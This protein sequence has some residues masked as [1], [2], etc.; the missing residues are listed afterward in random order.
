MTDLDFR[1]AYGVLEPYHEMEQS[2]IGN[3]KRQNKQ[4]KFRGKYLPRLNAR[5]R[6]KEIMS[7]V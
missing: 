6:K 1:E 5:Q 2:T 7:P 4:K 3:T